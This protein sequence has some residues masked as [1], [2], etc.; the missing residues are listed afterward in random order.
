VKGHQGFGRSAAAEKDVHI[1][2]LA[3]GNAE[4][5]KGGAFGRI[6]KGQGGQGPGHEMGKGIHDF[7]FSSAR[8]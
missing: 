4:K 8:E 2:E 5:H 7:F 6:A 1:G 3:G